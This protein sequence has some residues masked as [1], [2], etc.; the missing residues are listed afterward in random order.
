MPMPNSSSTLDGSQMLDQPP[1]SPALGTGQNPGYPAP[2]LSQAL[3]PAGTASTL[4]SATLPMDVLKGMTDTATKMAQDLDSFAQMTPDLAPDWAA[5]RAALST[6]M[7]KVLMAGGGPTSPTA[8]G[9]GF[10]GGG[11]DRGGQS[12]ASGGV[13]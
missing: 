5:V 4:S 1:P 12:L 7:A 9:P 8:T 2:N 11:L 13:G 3:G 10:P 6:A